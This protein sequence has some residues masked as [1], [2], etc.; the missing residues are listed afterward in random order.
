MITIQKILVPVDFSKASIDAAHFAASLAQTHN[1]RLYVLHVQAP[2]PVHGRI[3]AGFLENVQRQR[4]KKEKAQLSK[5]IPWKLKTSIAVEEI[6]V[7][8]VPVHQVIIEKAREFG[9]D[10]IV[11]TAQDRRGW[12]RIFKKNVTAPVIRN[13]PCSVFVF[14]SPR[15]K[16]V[17]AEAADI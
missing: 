4:I 3:V 16:D 14:R 7:T 1:A 5:L 10:V 2:F 17:S 6:Q 11:M 12:Q 9:I 15:S 8:G 13:A